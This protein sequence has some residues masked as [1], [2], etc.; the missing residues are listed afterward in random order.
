MAKDIFVEDRGVVTI[1]MRREDARHLVRSLKWSAI[2]M[3][4]QMA[5]YEWPWDADELEVVSTL[6]EKLAE[7]IPDLMQRGQRHAPAMLEG[8]GEGNEQG[9]D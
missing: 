9:V 8:I 1:T 3:P 6:A 7:A 4:G 2:E 5:I